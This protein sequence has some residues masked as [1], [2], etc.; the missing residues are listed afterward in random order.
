MTATRLWIFI[1]AMAVALGLVVTCEAPAQ[2][3]RLVRPSLELDQR[4]AE[5]LEALIDRHER[6]DIELVDS[7]D[8]TLSPLE[9]VAAGHADLAFA[10]NIENYRE[11]INVVLPLYA[12]IL[13]IVT[14]DDPVPADLRELF[15][16]RAIFAG[17]SSSVTYRVV[18]Q[19]VRD[20][21]LDANEYALVSEPVRE[22]DVVV[23]FAPI[24]RERIVA[25][26]RLEGSR[27]FSFGEVD[28]IGT[29]SGIDRA[30]LLNP[31]LK[32]FVIPAG[33]YDALTPEPVLTLAVD[34]L[35]V[36]HTDL[37]QAVVYDLFAEIVR[38]R[39]ALFS[40]RPELFQELDKSI[41]D[42]NFAFSMHPG[43]MSY[44]LQ[45]EPT[46]IERYSGVAEVLVTLLIG[47]ISGGWAL[48]KIYRIRRKNRIDKFY[49]DVIATRDAV[50]ADASD[51]DR[52]AAIETIRGLQ[53]RAFELLVDEKLAA[54]ESFRIF[55][56]LT[57]NS[58][59]ELS[60]GLS[61]G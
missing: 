46:F 20:L 56:E 40:E 13:H 12:R 43:A 48:V 31:R 1:I 47:L 11:D 27:L 24:D 35:L 45:D 32:P 53:N 8:P 28:D 42:A 59:D 50:Q 39:T 26:S 18:Q 23:V 29:G 49:V 52:L 22:P 55:I 21:Q 61:S 38:V 2:K 37:P 7:P 60:A 34:N 51:A 16:N 4:I 33:T 58:I 15:R 19:V 57:N 6:F 25:D 5:R 44:L 10:A 41:I 3:L 9:A 14:R 17:P 54:D 36:A 30:V